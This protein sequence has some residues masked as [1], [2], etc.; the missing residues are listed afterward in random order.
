MTKKIVVGTD[1]LK[2]MAKQLK[3]RGE[4]SVEQYATILRRSKQLPPIICAD[5]VEHD[6]RLEF[7][8]IVG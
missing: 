3:D 4:I 7:M 5:I 6:P 8:D 1:T 2:L